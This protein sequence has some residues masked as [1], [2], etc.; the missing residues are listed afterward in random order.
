MAIPEHVALVREGSAAVNQWVSG[1]PGQHLDLSGADLAG[2]DLNG[3]NFSDAGLAGANLAGCDLRPC[4][5]GGAD[6]RGANLSGADIRSTPL[7]R[8]KLQEA[9]FRGASLDAI[10]AGRQL[11]CTSPLSFQGARWDRERLEEILGIL[12]LNRDWE[13]KWEIVPKNP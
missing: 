8:A 11:I 2:L 7:H 3:Y 6:L 4:Q 5:L 1:N 10:G 13:I 9:D 12:N